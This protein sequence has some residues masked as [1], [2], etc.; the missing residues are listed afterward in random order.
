MVALDNPEITC[1][2]DNAAETWDGLNF[3]SAARFTDPTW[4]GDDIPGLELERAPLKDTLNIPR[5]GYA[6]VRIVSDNPGIWF[7]HCHVETH[8]TKG[9]AM[10]IAQLN[11][12]DDLIDEGLPGG[13]DANGQICGLNALE[14]NNARLRLEL[15]EKEETKYQ[16]AV[17]ACTAVGGIVL[18]FLVAFI[19]LRKSATSAS[20]AVKVAE[21]KAAV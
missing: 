13:G 17:I 1:L 6:I 4:V 20:E 14:A 3:C 16:A 15:E 11:G 18:G 2:G 12:L 10:M 5:G 8:N 9:M 7:M 21:V 19:A